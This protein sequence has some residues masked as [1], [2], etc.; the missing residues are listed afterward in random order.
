MLVAS[1]VFSL[2]HTILV[3]SKQHLVSN[4]ELSVKI[5][6]LVS[7]CVSR[8]VYLSTFVLACLIFSVFLPVPHLFVFSRILLKVSITINVRLF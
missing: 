1:C 2:A 4:I 5:N 7:A 6:L 8:I 3:K